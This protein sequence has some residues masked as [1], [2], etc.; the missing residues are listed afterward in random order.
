[1][2][3]ETLRSVLIG[4]EKIINGRPL[5]KI[6]ISCENDEPI[7]PNHFLL[8][9]LS[10]TC[11]TPSDSEENVCLRKQKKLKDRLWK[12]CVVEIFI[13]SPTG[14]RKLK[15]WY[16]NIP[17]LLAFPNNWQKG[18]VVKSYAAKDGQVRFVDVMS[19]SGVIRRPVSKLAILDLSGGEP[20][21]GSRGGEC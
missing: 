8:G 4:A 20:S 14:G 16:C 6:S 2:P 9:C 13:Q 10:S 3:L 5:T 18:R 15:I 21:P 7:I 19:L 11:R 1:M 12:R 17:W